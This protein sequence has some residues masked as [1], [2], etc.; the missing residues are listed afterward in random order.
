M[1]DTSPAS[2]HTAYGPHEDPPTDYAT[3]VRGHPNP[4]TTQHTRF[5]S[6]QSSIEPLTEGLV[7]D[8]QT[9]IMTNIMER[10]EHKVLKDVVESSKALGLVYR[11]LNPTNTYAKLS[12][13]EK[14]E[15]DED[16]DNVQKLNKA[17]GKFLALRATLGTDE[18]QATLHKGEGAKLAM[19]LRMTESAMQGMTAKQLVNKL[20]KE[21][22]SMK[23]YNSLLPLRLRPQDDILDIKEVISAQGSPDVEEPSSRETQRR[24][25][26]ET[27]KELTPARLHS[28]RCPLNRL[29]AVK[30]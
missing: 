9:D 14:I 30:T 11:V 5:P 8:M 10:E 18:M 15:F 19:L 4:S 24:L 28:H 16:T 1:S 29:N 7:S 2:Q 26:A 21:G 27:L 25:F 22:Y 23:T 3:A 20:K 12:R 17:L 13:N 6:S